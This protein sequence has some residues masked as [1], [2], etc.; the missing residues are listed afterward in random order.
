LAVALILAGATLGV[1]SAQPNESVR[2]ELMRLQ[3][4]TGLTLAAFYSGDLQVVL[5]SSRYL[6]KTDNHFDGLQSGLISSDG[7]ETILL[8][9][10]SFTRLTT[11]K[12]DGSGIRQFP[13]AS[14]GYRMCWNDDRSQ[15]LMSVEDKSEPFHTT[16]QILDVAT[17]TT[18]DI[19]SSAFIFLTPQC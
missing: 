6:A 18:R 8:G 14:G 15:I 11:A 17:K 2:A 9:N 5:F 1:T 7:T 13:N 19:D 16:L 10:R 4:R 12:L 3:T